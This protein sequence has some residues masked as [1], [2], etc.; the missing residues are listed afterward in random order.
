[1]YSLTRDL[2]RQSV[3][4]LKSIVPECLRSSVMLLSDEE[5]E[6]YELYP[7]LAERKDENSCLL[8]HHHFGCIFVNSVGAERGAEKQR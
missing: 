2:S 3:K 6:A 7:L 1:M 4:L 8:L 5:E